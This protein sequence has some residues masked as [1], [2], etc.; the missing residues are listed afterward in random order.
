MRGL[1]KEDGP[2]A[3][4][5][6]LNAYVH[7]LADFTPLDG[8]SAILEQEADVGPVDIDSFQWDKIEKGAAV[9]VWAKQLLIA[10]QNKG[11]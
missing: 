2:A 11:C 7:R 1:W 8:D 6:L 9:F 3:P 10:T 5:R 4:H